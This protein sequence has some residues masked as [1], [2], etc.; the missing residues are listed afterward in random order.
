MIV[1]MAWKSFPIDANNSLNPRK[2]CHVSNKH[3]RN[4]VGSF[5]LFERPRADDGEKAECFEKLVARPDRAT[6]PTDSKS[7]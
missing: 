3:C 6:G 4:P 7:F 1:N 5:C 2:G